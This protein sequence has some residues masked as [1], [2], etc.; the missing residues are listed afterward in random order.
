MAQAGSS[1]ESTQT[2]GKGTLHVWQT[3]KVEDRELTPGD[4]K[5]E[6]NGSGDR[7]NVTIRDSKK[8]AV[9]VPARVVQ[10]KRQD[11]NGY[12]AKSDPNGTDQLSEI[13]FHGKDYL[14]EIEPTGS[15]TGAEN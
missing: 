8:T 7:V 11:A 1:A 14:L 15:S 13:F 3:V 6:W 5:V 2:N 12:V 9:T 4:Y 10:D